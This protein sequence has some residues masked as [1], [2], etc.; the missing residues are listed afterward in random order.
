MGVAAVRIWR[1]AALLVAL[2]SSGCSGGDSPPTGHTLPPKARGGALTASIV[3][4]PT[5]AE[6][7]LTVTG[8]T[9]AALTLGIRDTLRDL[10]PGDY[11]VRAADVTTS[12]DIFSSV[13]SVVTV[14]VIAESLSVASVRYAVASGWLK[15]ETPGLPPGATVP[16]TVGAIGFRL[17]TTAPGIVRPLRPGRYSVN[18]DRTV[19]NGDRYAPFVNPVVDVKAGADSTVATLSY[20]IVSGRLI[21]STSGLPNGAVPGIRLKSHIPVIPEQEIG[22]LD[23]GEVDLTADT[24]VVAGQT[25]VPLTMFPRFQIA[26]STQPTRFTV[27][28][29]IPTARLAIQVTGVP[30]SIPASIRIY[31]PNLYSKSL[32]S[33][34]T[35]TALTPGHYIV[36]ADDVQD[37]FGPLVTPLEFDLT[38]NATASA[39][40]AYAPLILAITVNVRGMPAGTDAAIE[41]LGPGIPEGTLITKTTTFALTLPPGPQYGH[42]AFTPFPVQTAREGFV[43]TLQPFQV[44]VF[45]RVKPHEVDIDYV[46]HG[47]VNLSVEAVRVMQQSYR[48]DGTLPLVAGRDAMLTAFIRGDTLNGARP[49]IRARLYDRGALVHTLTFPSPSYAVPTTV[50]LGNV[51]GW[52]TARIPG[53]FVQPGLGVIVD[54]DPTNFY[55]ENNEAD[56]VFPASQLPI[57]VRVGNVRP[58]GITIVPIMQAAT[59][60]TGVVNST[61]INEFLNDTRRMLPLGNITTRLR[62]PFTISGQALSPTDPATWIEALNQLAA[63]RSAEGSNDHYY[64]VAQLAHLSGITGFG[65]IGGSTAIGWDRRPSGSTVMAHELGHNFGLGH[66][67]CGTSEGID[68]SHPGG[69]IGF[70]GVDLVTGFVYG[71]GT[72]DFMGYCRDP[73]ISDYHYERIFS[74][75]SLGT[76]SR[77]S[78]QPRAEPGILVWGRVQNGQP[79]LEPTFD[80]HAQAS[81]PTKQGPNRL[82]AI[83]QDG[84]RILEF[85]FPGQEVDHGRSGDRIFA[86]VIPKESLRGQTVTAWRLTSNGSSTE[87]RATQ[88]LGRVALTAGRASGGRVRVTVRDTVARGLLVRDA[89]S[90]EILS[91]GTRTSV[92]VATRATALTVTVSDGVRSTTHR[93]AV[94]PR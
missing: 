76:A 17:E 71:A 50:A 24:I 37:A 39:S 47:P 80:V 52:F 60:V 40:F 89:Q 36:H 29:T 26:A 86:F 27:A 44:F 41:F 7:T 25:Y 16:V 56:N 82:E 93:V 67:S 65:V 68:P 63:L 1:A 83:S 32:T 55:I 64:G 42:Y 14:R 23:A 6:P 61:N 74:N 19:H 51:L 73:W 3:G 90:G 34:T 11:F 20:S 92:S 53:A 54:V 4:L 79:I 31:G 46:N 75:V 21:V 15:I 13:D 12:S 28:Y 2:G 8:P 48:L 33:S 84:T 81:L 35:L 10:L 49:T 22:L 70:G 87:L 69:S 5:G 18:A 43:P 58:I 57:P 59:G 62:S 94:S 30:D 91:F 9:F 88:Q 38:N 66:S 72:P 45:P 77:Q 78:P 85:S